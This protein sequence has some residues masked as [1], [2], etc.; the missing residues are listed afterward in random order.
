MGDSVAFFDHVT[1][2]APDAIFGLTKAFIADTRSFKVNLTVGYYKDAHLKVPALDT[3]KKTELFLAE[4][5]GSKEYQTFRGDPLFLEKTGELVFGKDL[6]QDA[7]RRIYAAQSIGGTG[8]LKLGGDFLKQEIGGT[9]HISSP[10]WPNHRGVFVHCGFK[11]SGYPYYDSVHKRLDFE[12][13]CD[14]LK[15]LPPRD[16]VV[17]HACCHNPT[18]AD[19]SLEQWKI[20]SDLFSERKLIPFFDSAYQGFA[21]G[22][23]Q[24]PESIRLFA[25]EGHEMLVASSYSKNFSL[26]GERIGTFFL[27]AESSANAEKIGSRIDIIVRRIYS[28]P[29]KHGAAIIAHILNDPSL[30][31]EWRHEVD[32]MRERIHAMRK[33]FVASMH[34][35][36]KI[37]DFSFLKDR[38]G[39]FCF[40]GLR[41]DHVERL[42]SEFG[43]YLTADGRMNAAGLNHENLDYVT[44][45]IAAVLQT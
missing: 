24:D 8:A 31:K 22:I 19:L 10:S 40:T 17:L 33:S 42:I 12:R 16:I 14:Y 30:N 18:G 11:V 9:V 37:M 5:N 44:D 6:W 3:V 25:H 21:D 26:Y 41:S 15:T 2:A 20:L 27:V 45:S 34:A 39:L 23:D 7:H 1:E 13:L 35:K 36:T 43:V 4:K 28:N 38:N 32:S 29:P